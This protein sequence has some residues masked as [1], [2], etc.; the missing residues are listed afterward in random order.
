M[1][2]HG[3]AA[4]QRRTAREIEFP[5][6]PVASQHTARPERAFAQRIALVRAAV[7][8]REEATLAR[9]DEHLLAFV[10]HQLAAVGPEL[11]AFQPSRGK[12]R[13]H[14]SSGP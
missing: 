1:G 9:N 12:H 13:L 4:D 11:A 14:L 5:I 2:A 8:D 10:P 7:G 3:V 6:M